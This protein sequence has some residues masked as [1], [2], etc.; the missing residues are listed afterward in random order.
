MSTNKNIIAFIF[1]II[2]LSS[3][4]LAQSPDPG[5]PA[6]EIG[7]G[8]FASG[9]GDFTFPVNV[10]FSKNLS[11]VEYLCIGGD[12]QNA[13]PSSSGWIDDGSTVRL[14]TS[15]DSVSIGDTVSDGKLKINQ[16]GTADI[17]NLYNNTH[18]VITVH[19]EGYVGILTTT[20]FSPLSVNGNG[21]IGAGIYGKG[22]DF[23][24]S[25]GIYG[26][27]EDGS[28]IN[29]GVYGRA[30][31]AG[32]NYGV[33]GSATSGTSN[34]AGYFNGDTYVASLGVG[35]TTLT[36]ALEVAGEAQIDGAIRA[37]DSTGIGLRDDGGNLALWVEDGGELGIGTTTPEG[38]FEVSHDG[39][40]HD[41]VV[42]ASTGKVGIGAT[43]P[44]ELL[45]INSSVASAW[46]QFTG[47]TTGYSLTDGLII[48]ITSSNAYIALE[49]E[50]TMNFETNSSTKMTIADDGDVGIGDSTPDAK[51][52]IVNDGSGYSFRVDDAG[53]GDSSPFVIDEYG[54]VGIGVTDPFGRQLFVQSEDQNLPVAEFD[55]PGTIS[56]S[57]KK[58]LYLDF[59]GDEAIGSGEKWI[60]FNMKTYGEVGSIH[61]EVVY[62]TFTGSHDG[63]T[64]EDISNWEPGMVL[65]SKGEP[66]SR[67]MGRALVKVGLATKQKDP[68]VM[69][70]YIGSEF[71]HEIADFNRSK[72]VIRYNALG[73]GLIL[74]TDTN[75]DIGIGNL[76][77]SSARPGY[78][79]KQDDDLF[80]S[81]TVAKATES[82]NWDEEPLDTEKGFKHKLIACTY[83]S[84]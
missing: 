29:Y 13:W 26:Q 48:G 62:G 16:S 20:A 12:C 70:V 41:L 73:E 4:A 49:E 76:I 35:D 32:Q 18:N 81:Y 2:L 51:V 7:G 34:W 45:H 77:T 44:N 57:S 74:V 10:T 40:S 65:I 83:H 31:G 63:Q 42:D 56:K 64:D 58:I 6:S 71:P 72:P 80:H 43:N 79:E 27:A 46:I 28:S 33:Y 52:D 5:H 82:V 17:L 14:S 55:N 39:S 1:T 54:D 38:T 59:S 37:R 36:Y 61:S 47:S 3:T 78:G 84:G 21:I 22:I 11:V 67:T 25:Y 75:G 30:N 9:Y 66:V 69:G 68:A 50:G 53:E 24:S 19:D 15:S 23:S 8:T 60:S